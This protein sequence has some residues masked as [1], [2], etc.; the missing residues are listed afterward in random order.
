MTYLISG[1]LLFTLAHFL[2]RI[3]P[4]LAASVP[5]IMRKICV[6]VVLIFSVW[7]M[8]RGYPGADASVLW[9][10]PQEVRMT[11]IVLLIPAFI[12]YAG[13]YPGSAL[14][15]QVRHPQLTGFKLWAA[16]HLIMNGDVRSV[17]LFGGLLAWAAVQVVVLNRA[18]GKSLLPV[19]SENALIAWAAVP[20]G[21]LAWFLLFLG[22]QWLIGVSPLG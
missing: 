22:H 1:V 14:R 13:S 20:A 19:A 6:A 2:N 7:L 3:A 9:Q 12:L 18:S 21:L 10:V 5:V 8:I 11:G 4:G 17:V 15:A 16:L